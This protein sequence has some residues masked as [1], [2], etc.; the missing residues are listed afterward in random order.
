MG[1]SVYDKLL[2]S[3]YHSMLQNQD[4]STK[5]A[6]RRIHILR[7]QILKNKLSSQSHR[8]GFPSGEGHKPIHMHVTS[9][10]MTELVILKYNGVEMN[11]VCFVSHKSPLALWNKSVY[12]QCK[13]CSKLKTSKGEKAFLTIT[14][15]RCPK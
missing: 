2:P 10:V 5:H 13:V 7:Q 9:W 12:L 15:G 11:E 14:P 4:R 1:N 6:Y 3:C 8:V